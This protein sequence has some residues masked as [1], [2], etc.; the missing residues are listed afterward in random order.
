MRD[1]YPKIIEDENNTSSLCVNLGE[2]DKPT[3]FLPK[4]LWG[5]PNQLYKQKLTG[6]QTTKML[7]HASLQPEQNRYAILTDG[8]RA[9]GITRNANGTASVPS[10]LSNSG[11]SLTPKMLEVPARQSPSPVIA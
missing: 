9:L 7:E 1:T 6:D 8:L 11:V 10:V 2:T 3:W 5:F 4:H